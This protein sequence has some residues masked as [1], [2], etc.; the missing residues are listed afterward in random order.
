[1]L[2]AA[3]IIAAFTRIIC[4]FNQIVYIF[5]CVCISTKKYTSKTKVFFFFLSRKM[6]CGYSLGTSNEY[7]QCM[8]WGRKKKRIVPLGLPILIRAQLFKANDVV[9]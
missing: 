2:S 6:Y 7:L 5:F 4:F 8:F 3:I 9:S 1:M